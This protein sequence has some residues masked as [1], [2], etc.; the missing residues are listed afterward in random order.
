[1]LALMLVLMLLMLMLVLIRG[2]RRDSRLRGGRRLLL[3]MRD[4]GDDL[5]WGWRRLSLVLLDGGGGG[6]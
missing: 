6:G 5:R 4:R 3:R 1:M 2:W